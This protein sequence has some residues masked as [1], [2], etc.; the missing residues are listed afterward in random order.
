MYSEANLNY[1]SK[2]LRSSYD[3]LRKD[4]KSDGSNNKTSWINNARH[5]V[6]LKLTESL[7]FEI[8]I[9]RS[10]S[11]PTASSRH[12]SS[13]IFNPVSFRL[14]LL[15]NPVP[16]HPIHRSLLSPI[17]IY[18]RRTLSS[19]IQFVYRDCCKNHTAHSITINFHNL[20]YLSV[21]GPESF[22]KRLWVHDPD[23][24]QD[25][26]PSVLIAPLI[27]GDW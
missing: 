20:G 6:D 3:L 17:D 8:S 25:G 9:S 22:S 5:I 2:Q 27:S 12:V 26:P 13:C 19:E 15:P 16:F 4:F 14:I 1:E 11:R 10:T 24:V 7:C 21:S 23:L 18:Y